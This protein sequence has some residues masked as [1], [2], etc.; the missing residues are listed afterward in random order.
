MLRSDHATSFGA[1]NIE[2]G[3]P[4]SMAEMRREHKVSTASK[5]ELSGMEQSCESGL[6]QAASIDAEGA[7]HPQ[8]TTADEDA[9]QPCRSQRLQCGSRAGTTRTHAAHN[10]QEHN[11]TRCQKR[12]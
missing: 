8:E 1:A 9:N 6:V 7:T 12:P 5:Q 4:N 2:K 10:P 3:I 11:S